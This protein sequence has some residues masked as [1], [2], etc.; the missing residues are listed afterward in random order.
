[1]KLEIPQHIMFKL[2]AWRDMGDTEVTGF[3]ITQKDQFNKVIDAVIVKAECTGATV[4]ID[5]EAL[6]NLYLTMAEKN[7]Y[8]DQLQIWWHTH[9][10]N[11]ASPSGT[12]QT[13]F[14]ELG[15]DRTLNLMYILA[16]GGEEFAQ[17]SV[18]DLT[19][20]VMLK[21]P[22]EVEHPFEKWSNFPSYAD[23]K[24][25]YDDNVII[26]S[27]NSAYPNLSSYHNNLSSYHN[28][29]YTPTN[30]FSR[31]FAKDNAIQKKK[32]LQ[33]EIDKNLA[34]LTPEKLEYIEQL[35]VLVEAEE[36]TRDDADMQAFQDGNEWGFY[37]DVYT[38]I[39]E[40]EEDELDLP[41]IQR[42]TYSDQ[43]LN[44][45]YKKTF[46]INK[47]KTE[48]K[49]LVRTNKITEKELNAWLKNNNHSFK[50]ELGEFVKGGN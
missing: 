23:L 31:K 40:I 44:D 22:I 13:T 36:I 2:Q 45:V 37:T 28:N 8:P 25:D 14:K 41:L 11:S 39:L 19:T 7:I 38:E 21:T 9:P 10:G 18:T 33:V 48:L 35:H 30:R 34:E 42:R 16:C 5:A 49:D 32:N 1:M 20:K 17:L 15:Q 27:Y 43:L 50:Y 29:Y 47:L 24:K 46:G 6:E 26:Y 3:F 4:D 12:D